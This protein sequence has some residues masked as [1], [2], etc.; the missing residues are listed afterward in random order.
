MFQNNRGFLPV[1]WLTAL[2]GL[3]FL[4][5]G[6][7]ALADD[8]YVY[9]KFNPSSIGYVSSAGSYVED[10]GVSSTWGDEIQY[11]YFLSGSGDTR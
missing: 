1:L 8:Y 9:S 7:F 6:S 11:V 10:Y 2:C 5:T 3:V 4:M